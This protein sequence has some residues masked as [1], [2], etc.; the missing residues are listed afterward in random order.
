MVELRKGNR[1]AAGQLMELLWPEL[2]RLAAAQMTRE[3][4]NHTWQPTALVNELYLELVNA[5]SLSGS[6]HRNDR[7]A[8]LG[9]AAHMMMRLLIHHARPLR[10]RVAHTSVDEWSERPE[11][12]AD[13][14]D[15]IEAILSRLGYVHPELR[16]VVEMK[17]FE[18][19]SLE[20]VAGRLNTS[21]RTVE[22]R[23]AVARHWLEKELA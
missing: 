20:E 18:G 23:W 19:L 9:L 3:R 5:R 15:E 4:A 7:N 8:F 2:R 12:A 14:L 1:E 6:V 22:R 17:V 11:L 13:Q 21:L 10:R 16:A